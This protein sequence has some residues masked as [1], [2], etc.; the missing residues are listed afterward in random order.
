MGNENNG[1]GQRG[2]TPP[3]PPPKVKPG[4]GYVPPPPPTQ[5]APP[6]IDTR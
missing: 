1:N 3:L 6:P 5:Q 4:A 2:Y